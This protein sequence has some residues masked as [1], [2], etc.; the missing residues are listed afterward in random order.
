MLK[1][2]TKVLKKIPFSRSYS[3]CLVGSSARP[4][5]ERYD[6][7]N[8]YTID[9]PRDVTP[10]DGSEKAKRDSPYDNGP[11]RSN[12]EELVAKAPIIY[13]DGITAVCDG[14]SG[15]LGHPIEYIQLDRINPGPSVCKY[16]GARYMKKTH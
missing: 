15:G 6:Y 10:N 2:S 8:D 7:F 16:C 3:R 12:A 11:F 14:G 5:N 9:K 1:N 13:V 4:F